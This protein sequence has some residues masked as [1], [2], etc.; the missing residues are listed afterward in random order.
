MTINIEHPTGTLLA[1]LT[2]QIN[3]LE[4]RA[5]EARIVG[6]NVTAASMESPERAID[7]ALEKFVAKHKFG[8]VEIKRSSISRGAAR[9]TWLAIIT[10]MNGS[11]L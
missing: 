4:G 8:P 10:P 11:A 1:P 7:E 3:V 9:S 2:V 5:S 6:H